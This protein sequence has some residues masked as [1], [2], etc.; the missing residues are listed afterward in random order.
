MKTVHT[1]K[2]V[3]H[4]WA[5]QAQENSR[6]SGNTFFFNGSTIYSYGNH[7]PI[8]AFLPNGAIMWNDSSYS[9]TTS[10][11]QSH[12][13]QALSSEQRTRIIRINLRDSNSSLFF[14]RADA[15]PELIEM[16]TRQAG[17][18]ADLIGTKKR[19]SRERDGYIHDYNERMKALD[20]LTGVENPRIDFAAIEPKQYS[21]QAQAL[22][23]AREQAA[24]E[25]ALAKALAMPTK[26]TRDKIDFYNVA[27]RLKMQSDELKKRQAASYKSLVK[28]WYAGEAF[29]LPN[30][31]TFALVRIRGNEFETSQGARVPVSVA[32]MIWRAVKHCHDTK[33]AQSFSDSVGHFTLNCISETGDATIGCHVIQFAEFERLAK[34]LEMI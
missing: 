26:T 12:T 21:E 3:A 31:T 1:P 6:N 13:L 33:T 5:N 20:V 30:K 19:A 34:Q 10:R 22:K 16:A 18:L 28:K 14:A 15:I 32:P 24:N 29:T 7:F 23:A 4:L 8:A 11:H 17:K 9:N 25:L 27:A 2:M